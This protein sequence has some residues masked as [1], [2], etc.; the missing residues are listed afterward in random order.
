MLGV[1]KGNPILLFRGVTFGII[2]GKEVPIESYKSY[3]RSD[4]RRFS[5]TQIKVV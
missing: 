2:N 1:K 5:I 3:Y 4:N